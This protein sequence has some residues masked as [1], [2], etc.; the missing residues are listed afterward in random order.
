M[1]VYSCKTR[2]AVKER[3]EKRKIRER[4]K[5]LTKEKLREEVVLIS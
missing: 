3:G 4:K 1:T 5:E 2:E